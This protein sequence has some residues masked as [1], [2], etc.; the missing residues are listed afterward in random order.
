MQFGVNHLGHFA[1]TGQLLDLLETTSGQSRVVTHSSG[2]HERGKVNFED[3]HWEDSYAKWGAY[4]QSKL[5]NLLFA[6]ELDRK[7][8]AADADVLSTACHPG[9]AATNLQKRG[10]EMAGSRLRVAMMKVANAVLAQSA[11]TGALPLL[12]AATEETI[13][14]REYVGPGGFA[15]M[16]GTPEIQES[17][18]RSYDEETADRLWAV[19][20][21]QTGVEYSL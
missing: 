8:D 21:E 19:S 12:Y 17:N 6:Y 18:D 13:S 7:L 4:G 20:E 15:N 16:R 9:Y 11:E 5:A 1:L 10:P 14:G 2:A 3:L